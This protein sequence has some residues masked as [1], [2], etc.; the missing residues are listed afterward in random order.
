MAKQTISDW[1]QGIG[2][3]VNIPWWSG[4][5][6]GKAWVS[7]W[8]GVCDQQVELLK[9]AVK[10]RF[11]DYGPT[12]ALPHQAGDA[13]LILSQFELEANERQRIK[14]KWE[15]WEN[16]G[17]PAEFLAQL[18]WAGFGSA[19]LAQQNGLAYQLSATPT[20][21]VDP[22]PLLAITTLPLLVTDQMLSPSPQREPINASGTIGSLTPAGA[23]A[24][25]LIYSKTIPAGNPWWRIDDRTDLCNR[26]QVLLPVAAPATMTYGIA[27]FAGNDSAIVTWNNPTR[28]SDTTYLTLV[29]APIVASGTPPA[30]IWEDFASRSLTGTTINASAPWTGTAFVIAWPVGANPFANISDG[31]LNAL[32][33]L[34]RRWKPGTTR[35]V[36]IVV[37]VS[38][39]T[40]GWTPGTWGS[41][42]LWGGETV[43]YEAA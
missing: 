38:D 19:V 21:G 22:T 39:G 43:E 15:T 29:G 33:T 14:S 18:Y 34:I 36:G 40:W 17:Q 27:T 12:D 28:F 6:N 35:C 25:R 26:F 10:A 41:G 30:S 16:A 13:G 24:T 32:R 31:D 23:A 11:P 8:G 5:T 7:G 9:E 37:F 1:L 4:R 3:G 42:E 2:G 20:A